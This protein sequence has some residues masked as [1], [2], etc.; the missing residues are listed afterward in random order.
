M[1][2]M[3][4]FENA[5]PLSVPARFF[6]TAPIYGVLAGL[7]L[8]IEGGDLLLSRWT[9]A[10]LA[11][12]HLLTVGVLMQVMIG[13][14]F[15]FL[16]VAADAGIARPRFAA[17]LVHGTLNLGALLLS[18]GFYLSLPLLLKLAGVF[19]AVAVLS[20]VGF[21][22]AALWRKSH[23]SP[24]IPALKLAL[25]GLTVTAGF[26]LHLL[27]VLAFGLAGRMGGLTAQHAAWGLIGWSAT[28]IV[29][30]AYVVVPMFQLTPAYPKRISG[31][32]VPV[33][34]VLLLVWAL[35]QAI[36][37]VIGIAV[38][39]STLA[40]A[41][42]FFAT[43]TLGLQGK[44]RRAEVDTTFLYW[45]LAMLSTLLATA[46]WAALP[47]IEWL[48]P[49][50]DTL[51]LVLALGMLAIFGVLVAVIS[52]MLYKIAPFLCWLHLQQFGMERGIYKTPHM[53]VF[54]AERPMR[55]QFF[56]HNATLALLLA[57]LAVPGILTFAGVAMVGSFLL[58]GFNLVSALRVFGRERAKLAASS[59]VTAGGG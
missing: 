17:A 15:Q 55:V 27:V 2:A 56:W 8:L 53:G 50:V 33:L 12:T 34:F 42:G 5:P 14:L 45:R 25:V 41:L 16:P 7:L 51:P 49:T 48:A 23:T 52:G 47:W 58:L 18:F 36:G 29:G 19:L 35:V 9:P 40:L 32:L 21:A 39:G 10:A 46:I 31:A 24:S 30:V 38:V 20:F 1:T 6:A 44:S 59:G 11:L 13:A 43:L 28:L 57:A 54:L 37:S 3:L 22:F 4:S 26:G